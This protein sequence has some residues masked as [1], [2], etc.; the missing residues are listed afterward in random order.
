MTNE[1]ITYLV[2]AVC[3]VFALAAYAGF[4][5]VPAWNAYSRLWERVMAAFL[6]LYVLLAFVGLGVVGGA[7]VVWFW[8]RITG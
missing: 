6:S 2:A 8:D 5:L 7:A 4:I 1:S 3:G